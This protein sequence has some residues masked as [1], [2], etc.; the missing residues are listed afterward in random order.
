LKFAEFVVPLGH[1][2]GDV[3][4]S[5]GFHQNKK[6][7]ASKDVIKKVELENWRKYL[8]IIYQIR[9]YYPECMKHYNSTTTRQ[10]E[11]WARA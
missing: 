3:H 10:I 6:L 7:R 8:Q 5:V 11:K 4:R 2:G 1:P 9:V